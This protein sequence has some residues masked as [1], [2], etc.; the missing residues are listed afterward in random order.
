MKS[1]NCLPLPL[2]AYEL[3]QQSDGIK[4]LHKRMFEDNNHME[5]IPG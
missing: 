3:L 2:N 5:S 4:Q 1:N